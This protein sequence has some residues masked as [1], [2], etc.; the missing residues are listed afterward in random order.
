MH[1]FSSAGWSA[2]P[3]LRVCL[4]TTTSITGSRSERDQNTRRRRWTRSSRPSMRMEQGLWDHLHRVQTSSQTCGTPRCRQCRAAP[5][6]IVA[7]CR[8]V[9]PRVRGRRFGGEGRSIWQ[10][11]AS[12]DSCEGQII[13]EFKRG[14]RRWPSVERQQLRIEGLG[15]L[16][17]EYFH[18]EGER[19]D[20]TFPLAVATYVICQDFQG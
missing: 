16:R 6:R 15:V 13:G 4:P 11:D 18:G 17:R 9:H 10:G 7:F 2:E 5:P 1:A 3:S 19:L 12:G 14:G 20:W 8:R